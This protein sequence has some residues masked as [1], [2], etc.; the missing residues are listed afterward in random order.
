MTPTWKPV[1]YGE[2]LF[3]N[4]YEELGSRMRIDGPG[5]SELDFLVNSPAFQTFTRLSAT[6]EVFL[7]CV[8]CAIEIHRQSSHAPAIRFAQAARRDL[9]LPGRLLQNQKFAERLKQ[10]GRIAFEAKRDK[11]V[12]ENATRGEPNHCYLCGTL[13]ATTGLSARTIEHIWPLSLGGETV[14][15]NLVLAC[16]DCNSKRG[17]M[18]T[19]AYGPVHS[20]YYTHS[21]NSPST[22]S[23]PADLRLSLALAKL[24]KAAAPTRSRRNPLTLK[25]AAQ[26]V[27]PAI[28]NLDVQKDRPYVYFELLQQI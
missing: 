19:W 12:E 22:K 28:P 26:S 4:L 18:M 10:V 6:S 16:A 1:T 8:R 21:S 17:R 15:Q 7:R 2:E 14:G 25:E 5:G 23:P 27:R 20:T 13:F 9:D 11:V 3:L 24:L